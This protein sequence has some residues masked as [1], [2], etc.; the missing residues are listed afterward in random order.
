MVAKTA[1]GQ[2]GAFTETLY[3]C[4]YWDGF[5]THGFMV[6]SPNMPYRLP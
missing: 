2:L 5:Y 3:A 4:K 6:L 1:T